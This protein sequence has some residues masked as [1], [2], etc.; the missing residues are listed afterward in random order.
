MKTALVLSGGGARGAYQAGVIQAICEICHR[1]KIKN[2]FKIISGVSAGS[3]NGAYLASHCYELDYAGESL[4]KLWKQIKTERVMK[5]GAFSV[6]RTGMKILK[7]FASFGSSEDEDSLTGL[8]D[9]EPL[10]ELLKSELRYQLIEQNLQ[11]NVLDAFTVTATNYANSYAT[12]FVQ[13]LQE[14]DGWD[15]V[16]REMQKAEINVDHIMA[17][18]AIPL[19]FPSHSIDGVYY[20]DGGIRNTSPLSPA[21]KLGARQIIAVGVRMKD[22]KK[23]LSQIEG[24]ASPSIGHILSVMIHGLLMD[25]IDLNIER[26]DRVNEVAEAMNEKEIHGRAYHK[27]NYLWISPSQYLGEIAGQCAQIAPKSLKFFLSGLGGEKEQAD[28]LS[29]LLFESDYIDQLVQLGYEDA[30]AQKDEI[31]GLIELS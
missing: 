9:T 19:L 22:V 4:V 29:Y 17:S 6:G 7:Q 26:L 3:I 23:E 30:I 18:S 16:R 27:I 13:T 20:G 14:L 21:L 24:G 5:V 1:E 10:Y 11:R 31:K 2:P 15:R 28:L 8:M 25:A 12:T